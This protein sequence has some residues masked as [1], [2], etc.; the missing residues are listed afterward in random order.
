M[1]AISLILTAG[2]T[3]CTTSVANPPSPQTSW[4]GCYHL[5]RGSWDSLPE[6]ILRELPGSVL[7]LSTSPAHRPEVYGGPDWPIERPIYAATVSGQDGAWWVASQDSIVVVSGTMAGVTL[8]LGRH[9]T[10]ATGS[11]VTF[12][13][14]LRLTNRDDLRRWV[15][16]AS[17]EAVRTRC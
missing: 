13:D 1:R 6:P 8:F 10:G 4:A 14:I 2:V 12:T 16:H 17:L 5:E 3:A 7:R 11:V 15:T 9:G